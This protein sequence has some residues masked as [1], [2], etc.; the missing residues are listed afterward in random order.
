M[1]RLVLILEGEPWKVR[2]LF[3]PPPLLGHPGLLPSHAHVASRSPS[4]PGLPHMHV[5]RSIKIYGH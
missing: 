4:A 5:V 1:S 3:N 2:L